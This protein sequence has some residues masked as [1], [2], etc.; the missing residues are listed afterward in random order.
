MIFKAFKINV[1]VIVMLICHQH[2]CIVGLHDILLIQAIQLNSQG[3][4]NKTSTCISVTN[5]YQKIAVSVNKTR[6]CKTN[7]LF[8]SIKWYVYT[9]V[10]KRCDICLASGCILVHKRPPPPSPHPP[11]VYGDRIRSTNEQTGKIKSVLV[12]P[13]ELSFSW[14]GSTLQN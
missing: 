1:L 8:K 10:T 14:G 4:Y 3:T 9:C 5:L 7:C 11:F 12:E 13:Q 6:S 2:A